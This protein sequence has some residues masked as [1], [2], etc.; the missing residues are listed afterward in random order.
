MHT[1]FLCSATIVHTAVI[2]FFIHI[3]ITDLYFFSMPITFLLRS[4]EAEIIFFLNRLYGLHFCDRFFFVIGILRS[5]SFQSVL[6]ESSFGCLKRHNVYMFL[7][8]RFS[9]KISLAI[10]WP[11]DTI[12]TSIFGFLLSSA[13]VQSC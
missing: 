10:L 6:S 1:R 4:V 5:D 7:F 11:Y 2:V 13:S 8:I 9:N 12:G 3:E